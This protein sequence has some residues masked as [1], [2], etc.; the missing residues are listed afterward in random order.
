M[1]RESEEGNG[2]V[3]FQDGDSP[4]S[5]NVDRQPSDFMFRDASPGIDYRMTWKS[6]IPVM[7]FQVAVRGLGGCISNMDLHTDNPLSPSQPQ[8]DPSFPLD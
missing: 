6:D 4:D 1:L 5:Q 2:F 8:R 3:T 7:G